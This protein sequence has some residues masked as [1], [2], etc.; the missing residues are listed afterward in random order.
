[1]NKKIIKQ[2]SLNAMI[3]VAFFLVIILVAMNSI[4]LKE[5]IHEEVTVERNKT[6]CEHL[7]KQ[8]LEASDAMTNEM[9]YFVITQKT[10]HLDNYWKE[11]YETKSFEKA[12]EELENENLSDNERVLLND[13][14][15]NS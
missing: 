6:Y 9:R 11:R 5:C 4:I 12:I 15:R 3:F 8:I 1:M 13:I 14:K 2:K 7:S 10:S